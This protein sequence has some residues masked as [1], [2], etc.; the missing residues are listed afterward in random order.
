MG[1]NIKMKI[2]MAAVAILA[3]FT[4]VAT[5][6]AQGTTSFNFPQ[7]P[8]T[9][10]YSWLKQNG[11]VLKKGA[12]DS[13]QFKL[14]SSANGLVVQAVEPALGLIVKEGLKIHNFKKM[15]I[16]WG[17]NNYPAGANWDKGV[18][19]EPLMIYVFFGEKEYSSDSIFIPNSPP[20][21]GFYLG[22]NDKIGGCHTG[23]H[24]TTGGRYICMA[25]P[26]VG[27]VITTEI[28]LVAEFKKAFGDSI[29]MPL[30]ISGISI[31]SDTSDLSSGS[32]SSAFVT[33][34]QITN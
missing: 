20:F 8:Q 31:E 10:S 23:R 28:D 34:I 26:P 17:I 15:T 12:A 21:I 14:S 5:L 24:F 7:N 6:F 4:G 22:Q 29:P 2:R 11:F 13:S 27:Q 18:H 16:K 33:D 30:Y 25:N 1:D 19:N 3:C 32:M 9:D